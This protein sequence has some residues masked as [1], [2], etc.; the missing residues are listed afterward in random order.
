MDDPTRHA[1]ETLAAVWQRATTYR[2]MSDAIAA[3]VRTE[4]GVPPTADS[5]VLRRLVYEFID[6]AI[7]VDLDGDVYIPEH[8]SLCRA[9][10]E[11]LDVAER[12]WRYG[13]EQLT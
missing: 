9:F 8:S 11:A 6:M 3:A 2:G 5:P 4:L 1:I 13:A 7:T 10:L 12:R